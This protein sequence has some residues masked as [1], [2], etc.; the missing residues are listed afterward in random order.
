MTVTSPGN[1]NSRAIPKGSWPC[2]AGRLQFV[3]GLFPFSATFPYS[4]QSQRKHTMPKQLCNFLTAV[5]FTLE[6][7][8][9]TVLA[10]DP[11]WIQEFRRHKHIE[12]PVSHSG[13]WTGTNLD[14]EK[15][16]LHSGC[17]CPGVLSLLVSCFLFLEFL[18]SLQ[19][20]SSDPPIIP[21]PTGAGISSCLKHQGNPFHCNI[22]GNFNL[23]LSPPSNPSP[24]QTHTVR[25]RRLDD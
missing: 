7:I 22:L 16:P 13:S 3:P 14:Q 4:W 5:E 20:D 9:C 10:W 17:V 19:T 18:F 6:W 21:N 25:L 1:R 2:L 23:F 12:W 24:L 8:L 11:P 15:P